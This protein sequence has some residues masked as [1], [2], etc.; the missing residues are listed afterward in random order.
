MPRFYRGVLV[1]KSQEA[2]NLQ[3]GVDEENLEKMPTTQGNACK[4][5]RHLQGI[6][7]W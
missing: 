4:M 7:L 6:R 2:Q 5:P 1:G 3:M